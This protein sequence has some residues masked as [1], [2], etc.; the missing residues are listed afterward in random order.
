MQIKKNVMQSDEKFLKFPVL[1][2]KIKRMRR[3]RIAKYQQ[4]FCAK[5]LSGVIK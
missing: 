5:T 3:K 1:S 4:Q 2:M